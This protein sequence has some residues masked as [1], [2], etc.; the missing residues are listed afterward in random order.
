V[1]FGADDRLLHVINARRLAERIPN[2]TLVELEGVGHLPPLEAP[3]QLVRSIGDVAAAGDPVA[4]NGRS[5]A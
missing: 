4:K 1:P 3:G 5:A 2:A